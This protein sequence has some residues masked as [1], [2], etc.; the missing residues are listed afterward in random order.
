MITRRRSSDDSALQARAWSKLI[1]FLGPDLD[2]A[3]MRYEEIRRRLVA[4]FRAWRCTSPE[5]L[6]DRTID[7]VAQKLVRGES[8]CTSEP[9]HYFGGVARD[10]FQEAIRG[11]VRENHITHVT[12]DL[13]LDSATGQEVDTERLLRTLESCLAELPEDSRAL[14]LEYHACAKSNKIARRKQLAE[15]R[16]IAV[17]A[18]RIRMHR[19]RKQLELRVRERI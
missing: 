10:I 6:A 1:E 5:C 17:N 9:Y 3:A 14:V 2:S 11:Y 8:I 4:R 19:L 18:L 16:G 12:A 15:S 13:R 7:R